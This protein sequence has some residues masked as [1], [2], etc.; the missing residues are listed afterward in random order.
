MSGMSERLIFAI[1]NQKGG[2]GKTTTAINLGAALAEQ[3]LPVTIIDLDPQGNA[4]TGLGIEAESRDTT[5]YDLL[6]GDIGWAAARRLT[7]LP[8]LAIIPSTADLASAELDIAARPRRTH[9]LADAL[10]AAQGGDE[11]D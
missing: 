1:A 10:R 4:S 7:A 6:T 5:S 8:N 11:H 3:G 9:L 2:V